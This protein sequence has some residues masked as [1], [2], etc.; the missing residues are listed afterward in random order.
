MFAQT[1]T[2]GPKTIVSEGI[3]F[4]MAPVA[5]IV[6]PRGGAMATPEERAEREIHKLIRKLD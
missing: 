5:S 1:Q 6:S 3:G 4:A 2:A